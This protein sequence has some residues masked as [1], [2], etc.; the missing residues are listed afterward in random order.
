MNL[1]FTTAG[2]GT[3]LPW[4]SRWVA[5]REMAASKPEFCERER[6]QLIERIQQTI[7]PPQ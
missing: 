2:D 4:D 5:P 7:L 1:A 6:A 3:G